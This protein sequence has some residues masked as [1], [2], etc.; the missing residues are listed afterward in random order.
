LFT[1][2]A[3]EIPAK[4]RNKGAGKVPTSWDHIKKVD[5]FALLESQAS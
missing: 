3:T 2:K 4:K 5:F 1:T